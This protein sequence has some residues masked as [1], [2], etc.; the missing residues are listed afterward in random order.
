MEGWTRSLCFREEDG[1]DEAGRLVVCGFGVLEEDA[2]QQYGAMLS[3]E[4]VSSISVRQQH[5]P[6]GPHDCCIW[7]DLTVVS[8]R[9]LS[10][11]VNFCSTMGTA[12]PLY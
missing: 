1:V 4:A 9:M 6:S 3:G 5:V 12:R 10:F 11:S 7:S 8:S 2:Q